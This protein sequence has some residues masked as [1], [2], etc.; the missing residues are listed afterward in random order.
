MD[1]LPGGVLDPHS[2]GWFPRTSAPCRCVVWFERYG[3]VSTERSVVCVG[4]YGWLCWLVWL[5][6]LVGGLHVSPEGVWVGVLVSPEGVWVGVLVSREGVLDGVLVSREGV[7]DGV[8][9]SLPGIPEGLLVSP[10]GVCVCQQGNPDGVR[11]SSREGLDPVTLPQ[12]RAQIA[13]N[14]P[15]EPPLHYSA[16]FLNL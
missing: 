1:C 13:S 16:V 15:V 2:T 4:W 11:G 6:G 3:Y 10:Q 12:E 7:L 5:V 9:V 8:L 14:E